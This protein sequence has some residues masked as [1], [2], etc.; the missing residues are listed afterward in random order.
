MKV[1][2]MCQFVIILFQNINSF[3]LVSRWYNCLIAKTASTARFMQSFLPGCFLHM[4]KIFYCANLKFCKELIYVDF[5]S[6]TTIITITII[7]ITTIEFDARVK[8]LSGGKFIHIKR[9][10][11]SRKRIRNVWA[12]NYVNRIC[13]VEQS[14]IY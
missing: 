1:E 9:K 4:G 10:F 2:Q 3:Q 5:Q 12:R 7:R 13:I 8:D 14:K 11:Q 6:S